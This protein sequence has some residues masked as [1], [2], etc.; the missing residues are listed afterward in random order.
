MP[1]KVT[2]LQ[3]EHWDRL[4]QFFKE[5]KE[6]KHQFFQIQEVF[7]VDGDVVFDDKKQRFVVLE[8][9]DVIGY[10]F[11]HKTM[12]T[13]CSVGYGILERYNGRGISSLIM[14]KLHS[15]AILNGYRQFVA[16]V[17]SHNWR[18]IIVLYKHRYRVTDEE[19]GK[20]YFCKRPA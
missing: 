11:Y 14:E 8:G 12:G 16:C 19:D 3:K 4:V 5:F 18:S 1:Y 6:E 9:E 13:T 20:L 2:E 15:H 17:A 7:E 10:C